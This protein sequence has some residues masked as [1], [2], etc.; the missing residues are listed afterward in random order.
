VGFHCPFP[1][2]LTLR[3]YLQLGRHAGREH[4]DVFYGLGKNSDL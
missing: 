4:R 2:T 1:L 3:D